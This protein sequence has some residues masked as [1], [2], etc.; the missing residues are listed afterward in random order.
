MQSSNEGAIRI[1][2]AGILIS[3]ISAILTFLVVGGVAVMLAIQARG[4]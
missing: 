1:L 3:I 4:G 2:S